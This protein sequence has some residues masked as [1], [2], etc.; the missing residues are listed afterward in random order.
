METQFILNQ[1]SELYGRGNHN[2]RVAM[3]HL[4]WCIKYRY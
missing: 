2:V 1:N 3:W 4:Q